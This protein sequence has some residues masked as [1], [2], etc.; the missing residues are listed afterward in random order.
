MPPTHDPDD[1]DDPDQTAGADPTSPF[2][3]LA[4]EVSDGERWKLLRASD[5]STFEER[6]ARVVGEL[7]VRRRQALMML[8]FGLVEGIVTPEDLRSW[9]DGNDASTDAGIEDMIGWL[10]RRRQESL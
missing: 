8:L 6:F 10:R 7:P 9:L 1:P 5:W 2:I 4:M 3:E